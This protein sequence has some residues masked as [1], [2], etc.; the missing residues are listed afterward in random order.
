MYSGYL[1]QEK[2]GEVLRK[3]GFEVEEDATLNELDGGRFKKSWKYDFVDF[4]NKLIFEFDGF[5]HFNTY[6][7]QKL[8]AEKD[9]IT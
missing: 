9:A 5:R 8:D 2:L 6:R 7:V 4:N 1:T 3:L